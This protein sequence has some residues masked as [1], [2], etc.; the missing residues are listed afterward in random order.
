MTAPP[1]DYDTATAFLCDE[2]G[3]LRSVAELRQMEQEGIMLAQAM[4][5]SGR[6]RDESRRP[7]HPVAFSIPQTLYERTTPRDWNQ[8]PTHTERHQILGWPD[9]EVVAQRIRAVTGGQLSTPAELYAKA[10]RDGAVTMSLDEL[11]L[12]TGQFRLWGGDDNNW[13]PSMLDQLLA[14]G[15]NDAY[16]AALWE[17]GVTLQSVELVAAEYAKRQAALGAITHGRARVGHKSP[18]RHAGSPQALSQGRPFQARIHG[19]ASPFQAAHPLGITMGPPPGHRPQR[20][21]RLF[22]WRLLWQLPRRLLWRLLWRLPR[23]L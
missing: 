17:E 18:A 23:H 13:R 16:M 12:A 6:R 8:A 20:L 22:L 10:E 7:A 21:S 9:P 1:P 14:S 5:A 2:N 4:R 11:Q 3:V 15:G 19:G